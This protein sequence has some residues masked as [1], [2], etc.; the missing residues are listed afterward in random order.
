MKNE[1]QKRKILRFGLAFLLVIL[2]SLSV[3]AQTDKMVKGKIADAKNEPVIGA[4][5]VVKG[6]AAVGT[7]T[8]ENGAFMLAVPSGSQTLIISYLG[9]KTKEVSIGG[10]DNISVV[11]E[12]DQVGL[13]EVVVVGYGQQKKE[14]VVG[15][16]TQTTGQVLERAGGVS[17]V[18]AALTGNLPGVITSSSTGMPGA[19]DPDIIIRGATTWNGSQPLVLV[20]GIE[21]P[22]NSVDISS[23]ATVSVLKDASA[24]AIFGVNGANGVI[25][26]TTKRGQEGKA[27]INVTYNSTL[28]SVSKL[29]GKLDSYDALMLRNR[30]IESELG[31]S[32]DSWVDITPQD[33]INKYRYPANLEES[34]RYPNVNWADELFKNT[35]WSHNANINISGGTQFVKYYAA[36]DYLHEGDLYKEWNNNRGYGGGYGFNRVN[37]RSNLDFQLTPTTLLKSNLAGSFGVKKQPYSSSDYADWAAVYAGA[38]DM[39]LPRY[40]DGTWG[41]YSPDGNVIN[42]VSRV[43][44]AGIA[45]N[46]TTQITTD[47]SLDQ[48]LKMIL[49]GLSVKGSISWDNT[50]VETNRG[51]NDLNH[52]YQSKWINPVTGE[53]TYSQLFNSTT[54]FDFQEGINW[55][56]TSGSVDNSKTYRNLNYQIQLNYA[57]SFGKNNVTAMGMLFR[58]ERATGSA[59]PSYREDWKFRVTYDFDKRYLIEMNGSY[60][61]S[62]QFAPAYR[63]GFFGSGALGWIISDEK[64]MKSLKFLDMLKLRGSFGSIGDD[65]INARFVYMDQWAYGGNTGIGL[66]GEASPY[67]WYRQT[68][69]GNPNTHWETV[70]KTNVGADYSFLNGF[71]AGSVDIFHDNRY[72]VYMTGADRLDVPSYFGAAPPSANL[73][74]MQSHGYE[75]ELRVNKKLG[76]DWR[77]WGNFNMTHAVDKVIDR[78]D[79]EL[80]PDYQKSAG[81]ALGQATTFVNQGMYN[82]WD[83][84]YG[85]TTWDQTDDQK[86]PGNYNI[87][88][89]NGDGVINTYDQIPYGYSNVPQNTYNATAGV[90]WKGFSAFVQFYGVNNV[91]RQVVFTSLASKRDAAWDEGALWSKDNTTNVLPMPR[92]NTTPNGSYEAG[93]RYFFDGSYV[94]LKNM[95]I[96]YTFTSGWIKKLGVQNLKL[97]V[98]GDNLWVWTRMPDD[99]ESNFAGTGWASQGAYPTVKRYNF[100]LKFTL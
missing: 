73:G 4:S 84:L 48:D 94:R 70:Q 100:G 59:I 74:R 37:M 42:S 44:L 29:P 17:S 33:I 80:L 54:G 11:L 35:A 75:L 3:F 66:N 52:A 14:S 9:M 98:N 53:T 31:T 20:D 87:I 38:P 90:E 12:D 79:P 45:N 57:N 89:Y 69:V 18:G 27:A 85:S 8:D 62:E 58:Q 13:N 82:T 16:I 36:I 81:K 71:F 56:P 39:F 60:D 32:P 28:K 88:D 10:K 72:G 86:L 99:R 95:E 5:V 15:S 21:R 25:L 67:T 78:V 22:M 93:A 61:G 50:F 46:T 47:F 23:V 49:K 30:V 77:L 34:E 55:T 65:N 24:T 68:I 91:T 83:Q 1:L 63:F 26:I 96:A 40:S 51:I 41:Y 19:E 2:G 92:W 43:A 7:A 64:F 6:K 76:R 97:Y